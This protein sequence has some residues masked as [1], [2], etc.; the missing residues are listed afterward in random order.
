MPAGFWAGAAIQACVDYDVV[1]GYPDGKYHPG[2]TCA[3]DQ[4]A[5]YMARA[6]E[7]PM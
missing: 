2:D 3:R 5:V 4:M 1:K 6:F 7:L